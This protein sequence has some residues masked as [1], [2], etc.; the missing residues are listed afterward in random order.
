MSLYT[1][2]KECKECK[3]LTVQY[4]CYGFSES[5]FYCVTCNLKHD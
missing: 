5:G 2:I 3:T 4:I 1:E